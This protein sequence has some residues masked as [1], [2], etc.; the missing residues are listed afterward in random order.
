MSVTVP[1][2]RKSCTYSFMLSLYADPNA[3]VCPPRAIWAKRL[4][5]PSEAQR[6]LFSWQDEMDG[7]R[8]GMSSQYLLMKCR[9]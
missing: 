2:N 4:V 3:T 1:H 8:D 9:C 7:G 5:F 6:L